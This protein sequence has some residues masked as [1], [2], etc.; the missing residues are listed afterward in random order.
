MIVFFK[1]SGKIPLD[2]FSLLK[3]HDFEQ[4]KV[5]SPRWPE[6]PPLPLQQSQRQAD[7]SRN[8]HLG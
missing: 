6:V 1:V 2:N 5:P 4:E 3:E 8:L 7:E